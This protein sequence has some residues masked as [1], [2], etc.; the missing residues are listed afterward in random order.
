MRSSIL[1]LG[2][3]LTLLTGAVAADEVVTIFIADNS[4]PQPLVGKQ[5]SVS[6]DQTSYS[7]TCASTVTECDVSTGITIVQ[8]PST[9]RML[10]TLENEAYTVDCALGTQIASCSVKLGKEDWSD[11]FTDTISS[12]FITITATEA[13]TLIS[14]SAEVTPTP[15]ETS[16]STT[17]TRTADAEEE[18]ASGEPEGED[19]AEETESDNAAMAMV[20]GMPWAVGA[21]AMG[22]AAVMV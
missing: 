1:G 17:A 19:G 18:S 2:L 16:S 5:I 3:G 14:T 15:T 8:G 22:M 11:E 12:Y 7:V 4:E 21:V 13:G 20:T 10:A 9:Y 6:S